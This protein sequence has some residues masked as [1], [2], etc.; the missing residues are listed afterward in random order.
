MLISNQTHSAVNGLFLQPRYI[1]EFF[2]IPT[3]WHPSPALVLGISTLPS[4]TPLTYDLTTPAFVCISQYN[5]TLSP[6]SVRQ[7]CPWSDVGRT[8]CAGVT[9]GGAVFDGVVTGADAAGGT[10]GCG[11]VGCGVVATGVDPV[12]GGCC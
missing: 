5:G 8:G 3:N 6:M 11:A 4:F 12:A 7:S 1:F 9:V 2:F 10:T